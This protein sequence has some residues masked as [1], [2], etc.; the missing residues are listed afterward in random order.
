MLWSRNDFFN[1]SKRILDSKRQEVYDLLKIKGYNVFEIRKYITAYDYFCDNPT[2]FDGATVVKDLHDLPKLDL[3]AMLHDY[4][5]IVEKAGNNF[6]SKHKAD[7][8]YAKGMERKGK[9]QYSAYS[10]FIALTLTSPFW[11]LY[12]NLK[13]Y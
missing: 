3:D 1:Q 9:G 6:K 2:R 12:T 13:N 5:Y 10:R 7:W 8:H 4:V 11:V